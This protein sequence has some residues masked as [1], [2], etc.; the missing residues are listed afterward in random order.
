LREDRE[1]LER[2]LRVSETRYTDPR[3]IEWEVAGRVERVWRDEGGDR[4]RGGVIE[5]QVAVDDAGEGVEVALVKDTA[6]D[7]WAAASAYWKLKD[8][9]YAKGK[10]GRHAFEFTLGPAGRP[11]A[12]RG[13]RP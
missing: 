4:R 11:A 13:P 5:V 2:R 8:A 9:T 10:A 6:G 7:P 1:R 12:S 3:A